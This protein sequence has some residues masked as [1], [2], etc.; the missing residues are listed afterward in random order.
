MIF[1]KLR[2]LRMEWCSTVNNN[3]RWHS[4]RKEISRS[5]H[6]CGCP[7][8]FHPA[9]YLHGYRLWR[10]RNSQSCWFD[11]PVLLSG[12]PATHIVAYS[13]ETVVAEKFQTMV[14]RSTLNSR[15]KDFFDSI[16]PKHYRSIKWF[17]KSQTGCYL[18]GR[19]WKSRALP[20]S[21]FSNQFLLAEKWLA[22]H[23]QKEIGGLGSPPRWK[24]WHG[25]A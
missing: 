3:H 14:V 24:K 10:H 22:S 12:F 23:F 7:T 2:M 18:T 21:H 17:G 16:I 5:A 11:Y 9:G 20:I 25:Q 19:N 8:R 1:A 15:M 4:G 6:Q 13:L